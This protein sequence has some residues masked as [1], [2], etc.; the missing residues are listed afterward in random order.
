MG[1]NEGFA[2]L[3]GGCGRVDR[4]HG[5]T[6]NGNPG[7]G[8]VQL[9]KGP[10]YRAESVGCGAKVASPHPTE[11]VIKV[12]GTIECSAEAPSATSSVGLY[13]TSEARLRQS[14]C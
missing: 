14:R 9:R 3:Q 5:H 4:D 11:G 12:H 7:L 13:W 10:R 6:R 2:C 8:S 1:T